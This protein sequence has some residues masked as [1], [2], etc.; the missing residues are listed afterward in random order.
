METPHSNIP[1]FY[2][3]EEIVYVTGNNLPKNSE[4][5]AYRC[6]QFPCGCWFVYIQKTIAWS[7]LNAVL[8]SCIPHNCNIPQIGWQHWNATS[9]VSKH[10]R[11]AA[12]IM[13]FE[14]IKEQEAKEV[15]IEN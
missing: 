5:I 13:S 14:N 2:P 8:S 12:K 9:F 3:G 11:P 15:L 10:R 1:P 7:N 6:I 4:H